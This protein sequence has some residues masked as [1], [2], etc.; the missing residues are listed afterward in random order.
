MAT[1]TVDFEDTLPV[2][3]GKEHEND[4]NQTDSMIERDRGSRA[5][6]GFVGPAAA[7]FFGYLF[8]VTF[9]AFFKLPL[10]IGYT[11][12]LGIGALTAT[13]LVSKSYITND[14]VAAFVTVNPLVTLSGGGSALVTYG[15]G[16]HFCF[17]WEQ[18]SGGNNV[19]LREA[20]ENFAVQVQGTT[21][22]IHVKYSVRLRPD[23]NRLPEFLA[24]AASVASDL[25]GVISAVIVEQ[26]AT[27]GVKGAVAELPPLNAMLEDEFKHGKSQGEKASDF[28]KRFGV[29]IGD[30]TVGE[31]L[32]SKEVQK[33]LDGASESAALDEV[34][35]RTLGYPS[36]KAVHTAV[37]G[38]KLT[39]EQVA[40]ATENALA[41]TDNLHGMDVKRQTFTLRLQGDP[42]LIEAAKGL[43]P[44][45]PALMGALNKGAQGG[46]QK[47]AK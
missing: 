15:P 13:W 4:F 41:M 20:A 1:R 46:K 22:T 26:L 25:G 39:S 47:G 23:I 43:V 6:I 36:I 16:F 7:L 29:I 32:P 28:E 3:G 18:R 9:A 19:D 14:A 42:D 45:A 21:G 35:A 37:E 24:G 10:V 12:G 30:V 38:G 27:K 40:Y 31:I 11:V 2:D 5:F 17:P 33:A 8:G 44:I 34:V